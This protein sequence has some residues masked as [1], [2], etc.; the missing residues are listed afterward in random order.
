[1]SF[2]KTQK[3]A[4]PTYALGGFQIVKKS[5]LLRGE[6]IVDGIV[7]E[8]AYVYIP[9]KMTVP[10]KELP[11]HKVQ[12]E[13]DRFKETLARVKTQ[14]EQDKKR[15]LNELGQTEA[16]I[17]QSHIL[18]TKDPFFTEEVP[19]QIENLKT[20]AEWIIV[21]GLKSF[22][23][24]FAM[25]DDEFFRE[26][27]RD[28]EDVSMRIIKNLKKEKESKSIKLIEGILVV[29]ELIP[30]M[31]AKINP[32][33]IKGI[34]AEFGGETSHA[35]ILA[36][37]LGVPF[38]LSV[39]NLT[40]QIKT[41][42]LLIL[43]GHHG[44]IIINPGSE[45]IERFKKSEH[46]Y[47]HYLR[48]LKKRTKL[49]SVTG[50]GVKIT[51]SANIERALDAKIAQKYG[52]DGIGLFRTELPFILKDRLLSE[53]EQ[54]T[55]YTSILKLFK[56]KHVTIRT[57]DIGGDK[58][59]PF[60]ES[61]HLPEANPFL[62]LRSIRLSL[63]KPE[64]FRVQIRALLGASNFGKINILVPM[65]SSCEE[66]EKINAI[67]KEER[68]RLIKDGIEFDNNIKVGVMIEIPSAA[69]VAEGLIQISDFFSV[70]TNDLIQYTLAVDRTNEKV[71]SYYVPENP[72]VLK[73]IQLASLSAVKN[74]KT[75]SV[76]GELAGVP[77]FAPFF[78]GVGIRELSM[79]PKLIPEVKNIIRQI[80][81]A[82][83]EELAEEVLGCVH[84]QKIREIL[85]A[86][87]NRHR[88]NDM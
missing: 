7:I 53:Q 46:D 63:L 72:A 32:R 45:V 66:M 11:D 16:D 88:K 43:D 13:I 74:N 28:I 35:T 69:L 38:I 31:I 50:D 25:L 84:A 12:V 8:K 86:F 5:I 70:G 79:E 54:F 76:C 61:L 40:D 4:E 10:R 60:Q 65:I 1:M 47:I 80:T 68:E 57:L 34:L 44:E 51:L 17:F 48:A 23:E 14:L 42:D 22:T 67:I 64:V 29:N 15:V 24:T 78:L 75:C 27:V 56:D 21:N 59:F 30:S 58:F 85:L 39:K 77:Y 81:M 41:G 18:I 71:S 82:E 52:A 55:L 19:K 87:Y 20:N 2:F 3:T 9:E 36:K 6:G 62:G 26:R 49:P 73:L 37:S 33:K 83:A